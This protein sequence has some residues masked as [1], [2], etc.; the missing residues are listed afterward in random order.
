MTVR[1]QH[2]ARILTVT[3]GVLVAMPRDSAAQFAVFDPANF[4]ELVQVLDQVE[5]QYARVLEQRRIWGKLA[6][7]LPDG[8]QGAYPIPAT[9]W[10]MQRG[11]ESPDPFGVYTA[12][13]Q[14]IETGDPAGQQWRQ[15]V[16]PLDRY[17]AEV[18]AGL[19]P[20]QRL[21]IS[22]TYTH[23]LTA[24]GVGI[25]GIHALAINRDGEQAAARALDQLSTHLR[26]GDVG[27]LALLQEL[28]STD[29]L[30]AREEHLRNVYLAYLVEGLVAN[31]KRYRDEEAERLNS[32]LY[33]HQWGPQLSQQTTADTDRVLRDFWRAL[34]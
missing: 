29:V 8:R 15:S 32:I 22:R 17:P 33:E 11:T 19:T 1:F 20:T 2:A 24:D 7:P 30:A 10:D 18:L 6:R 3:V 16:V 5:Q 34:P 23:P 13:R 14:A 27:N 21:Q 26:G 28:A 9:P 4:A 12:L 31:L 25:V